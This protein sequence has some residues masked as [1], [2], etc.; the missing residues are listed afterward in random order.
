MKL[1]CHKVLPPLFKDEEEATHLFTQDAYKTPQ[2]SVYCFLSLAH[3]DFL[4]RTGRTFELSLR[5]GVLPLHDPRDRKHPTE[6]KAVS[7]M[8]ECL[9]PWHHRTG[10]AAARVLLDN[11]LFAVFLENCAVARDKK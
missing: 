1:R 10:P 4:Y 2:L 7:E 3:C 6:Q 5:G 11:C 8:T 9:C